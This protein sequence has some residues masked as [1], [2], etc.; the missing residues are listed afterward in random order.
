[1]KVENLSIEGL[2]LFTLDLHKDER[3][4]FVES[5][6]KKKY[7]ELGCHI[8]FVQDNCALS[9][10]GTLRGMHYQSYPGQDKL[11]WVSSGKIYDVAVDLR[12]GSFTYG[13]YEGIYLEPGQQ[14]LIPKGFAHGYFAMEDSVVHYKVSAYYD[15]KTE[16]GFYYDD[17]NVKIHWPEK[18]LIISERD[19]KA[20]F[21]QIV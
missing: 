8:D 10:K 19:Q 20:P 2:K 13:R 4:F 7:Q 5:Y 6:Q 16:K 21:L 1:M 17:P 14:F 15:P 12:E 3:G 18:P 9:K 11:I